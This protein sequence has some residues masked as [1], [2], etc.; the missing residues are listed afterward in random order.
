MTSKLLKVAT[1]R[2]CQQWAA[3][4][5]LLTEDNAEPGL[6][7]PERTPYLEAVAQALENPLYNCIVLVTFAQSGKTE[8]ILNSIGHKLDD[9]PE[10]INYF[11]PS[12]KLTETISNNRFK[13]MLLNSPSLKN[14]WARSR[15]DKITEKY[16]SGVRLGFGWTSSAT[17]LSSHP[18]ARVYLDELD[19]MPLNVEG[20]GS[21][22]ELTSVRGD[23]YSDFKQFLSSTPTLEGVSP[24]MFYFLEGTKQKWCLCCPFCNDYFLPELKIFKWE[25]EKDKVIDAWL[26][27]PF[28]AR[29]IKDEWRLKMNESAVYLGPGQVF[30]KGKIK[31]EL[32]DSKTASFWVSGLCSPWKNYFDRAEKFSKAEK[33]KQQERVQAVVNTAFG[34]VWKLKGDAPDEKQASKLLWKHRKGEVLAGTR[35][36]TCAVDVHRINLHWTLRGWL[37]AGESYLFDFG[38]LYGDTE[39]LKIWEEL[40]GFFDLKFELLDGF[41]RIRL[42]AIDS[43]YR[44]DMIHNFCYRYP[45]KTL[46]CRGYRTQNVAVRSTKISFKFKG[47]K[48]ERTL[49]HYTFSDHYFK[50]QLYGK[51]YRAGDGPMS[52]H[53][54]QD[55]T[56]N[57]LKQL[58]S[59]QLVTLATGRMAWVKQ[60]RDN[61]FL[62]CEKMQ[63][64]AG[65]VLDLS[66]LKPKK[67]KEKKEIEVLNR[68]LR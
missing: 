28:C 30:E 56:E 21:P 38:V 53:L 47:T 9:R 59:E 43:S 54:T 44:P 1:Q 49:N 7:N 29:K 35:C 36:I 62:D 37:D 18:Y 20:E 50:S 12:Q 42:M 67:E 2:N 46:P 61:H 6:Y 19:R 57:F 3:E 23:T 63:E 25:L 11:C 24:I 65:E 15:R 68:G 39:E 27:C 13:K 51:I 64:I 55:V 41:F 33:S 14:K 60:Q 66:R 48:E 40:A 52:Y 31:G 34:E 5:R 4:N 45:G 22:V 10:P 58:V 32:I 8:L 16:I 26:T 17:E